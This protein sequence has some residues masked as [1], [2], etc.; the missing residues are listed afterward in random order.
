[1]ENH[2]STPA[3][4]GVTLDALI[5]SLV[6]RI[7]VRIADK[8]RGGQLSGYV[9]QANSPLGRRNHIKAVR[10]GAL[11][12]VRIGRRY[13]AIREDVERYIAQRQ[14]TLEGSAPTVD[15][16]DALATELGFKRPR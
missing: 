12:G 9:D 3:S 10:T 1:V 16:V 11:P 7:A 14:A 13:L 6:E 15:A 4:I 2:V 5:D 8:L